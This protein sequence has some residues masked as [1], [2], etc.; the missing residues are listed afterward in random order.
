MAV[1]LLLLHDSSR[2]QV[3][4]CDDAIRG[5]VPAAA[6][7]AEY[8]LCLQGLYARCPDLKPRKSTQ[9]PQCLL[10]VPSALNPFKVICFE[11]WGVRD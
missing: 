2:A 9:E 8:H 3:E 4:F 11:V 1:K 5:T 6:T 10:A 7:C